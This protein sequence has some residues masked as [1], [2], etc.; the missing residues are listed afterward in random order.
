[1]TRKFDNSGVGISLA[2]KAE[3][4]SQIN[5]AATSAFSD[6]LAKLKRSFPS[7]KTPMTPTT[8]KSPE[9][10]T[11][12]G[13]G[14]GATLTPATPN[15]DAPTVSPNG[16]SKYYSGVR[17]FTFTK[18]VSEKLALNNK[19]IHEIM[20]KK[21]EAPSP[22]EEKKENP[23]AKAISSGFTISKF[24][25]TSVDGKEQEIEIIDRR[26][27]KKLLE[28]IVEEKTE[29]KVEEI[30]EK[31]EESEEKTEKTEEQ[32][33]KTEEQEEKD[34]NDEKQAK[35]EK[36]EKKEQRRKEK[37]ER[38]EKKKR[39]REEKEEK[40]V[41]KDESDKKKKKTE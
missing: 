35:K 17:G 7:P 1:M 20:G 26:K 33:E 37:K 9:S 22:S 34:E 28:P 19:N 23:F 4:C 24:N 14:L 6:V 11:Y 12:G 5:A 16:E 30:E 38:K 31:S 15:A 39:K 10:E 36:K 32:E 3:K 21:L 18:R 13:L 8:P 25:V 2:E 29:E 41:E 40:E 27:A